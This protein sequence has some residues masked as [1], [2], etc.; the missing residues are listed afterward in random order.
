V[1][2]TTA[3]WWASLLVALA[4]VFA[5]ALPA[6][7]ALPPQQNVP[8]L[9]AGG[10]AQSVVYPPDHEVYS[11][12]YVY[13]QAPP[14]TRIVGLDLACSGDHSCSTSIA[15]DGQSAQGHF[16]GENTHFDAPHTIDL[17]AD[18]DAP[19][20]GGTFTGSYSFKGD[21]QPLT[22][23]IAP[24]TPGDLAAR[25][26]NTTPIGDGVRVVSVDPDSSTSRTLLPGDR[27]VAFAG[28]D[29]PTANDLDRALRNR[30]AGGTFPVAVIR[31]GNRITIPV[32]LDPA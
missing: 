19:Y 14:H 5:H 27:I 32:T 29:T 10:P 7:A 4:A 3:R 8:T 22:V 1:I 23:K 2:R 25:L 9:E 18:S 24:G 11:P 20:E 26:R 31:D 13:V 16:T 21:T 12:G 28:Q 15:P 17:V 30:R 6:V